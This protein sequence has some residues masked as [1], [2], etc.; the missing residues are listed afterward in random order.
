MLYDE[1][2]KDMNKNLSYFFKKMFFSEFKKELFRR[3]TSFFVGKTKC[4][5][6]ILFGFYINDGVQ[7]G[8]Q[9]FCH[10]GVARLGGVETT[11]PTAG[12]IFGSHVKAVDV[13]VALGMRCLHDAVERGIE[14]LLTLATFAYHCA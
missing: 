12:A 2:C 6:A 10:L 8:G 11:A 3:N 1:V 14:F 13:R 7:I 4:Y 5:E 9:L